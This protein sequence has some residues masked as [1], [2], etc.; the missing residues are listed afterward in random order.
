MSAIRRQPPGSSSCT[1]K[2]PTRRTNGQF[3]RERHRL[4]SL[5]FAL[6]AKVKKCCSPRCERSIG[7]SLVFRWAEIGGPE[8]AQQIV[9]PCENSRYLKIRASQIIRRDQ[10]TLYR[11][12]MAQE[13]SATLLYLS[14]H[15]VCRWTRAAVA[16]LATG[17]VRRR[18]L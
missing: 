15:T 14:F 12:T 3:R 18:V 10:K 5:R 4:W 6:G 7:Q 11:S 16:P 1:L 13:F 17:L 8:P 9:R 2:T